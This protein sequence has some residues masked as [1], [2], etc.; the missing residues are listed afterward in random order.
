MMMESPRLHEGPHR[1]IRA[2]A[3]DLDPTGLKERKLVNFE[4]TGALPPDFEAIEGD[5]A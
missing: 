1:S 4:I 3:R 5:S 2:V